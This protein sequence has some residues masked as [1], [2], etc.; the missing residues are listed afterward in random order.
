MTAEASPGD[1]PAAATVRA[2]PYFPIAMAR[3]LPPHEMYPAHDAST[4]ARIVTVASGVRVRVVECGVPHG[5]AVLCI[6]G[7]SC[8]AYSFRRNL[9]ALTELGYRVVVPD[10]KGHGL[11]DKPLEPA[12]YTRAAMAAHVLEIM[13]AVGIGEAALVGHS[14]GGAIAVEVA[15]RAPGRVSRLALLAPVGFG[16]MGELR[17]TRAVTPRAVE[18]LLRFVPRWMYAAVIWAAYGG[19]REFTP[20]D[21][22]EY[23]APTQ[24]PEHLRAMRVL[25]HSFSWDRFEAREL[26]AI[27][28]PTLVMYGAKDV[29]AGVWSARRRVRAI[30]DS[31]F[32]RVAG[33][34]HVVAEQRPEVVNAQL[35]RFLDE[36]RRVAGEAVPA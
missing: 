29:L 32:L 26:A 23:W 31:R 5:P 27:A 18:P 12:A 19:T 1:R 15:L 8:S 28:V 9:C 6:H 4:A 11:S 33:A 14:M 16:R 13:D 22:D 10:L 35:V 25:L 17:L 3:H 2:P 36:G 20:R 21:V 34:G 30:R 7:W 24:W